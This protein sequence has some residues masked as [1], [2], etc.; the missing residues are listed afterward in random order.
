MPTHY[1]GTEQEVLALDTFIKLTR[2]SDAIGARLFQAN[3]LGSL[4][5]SQFGALEVLYHLGS[6]CQGDIGAK[7]LKSG[8]N[9]TLVIDNLEKRGLVTRRRDRDDR[10]FVTVSLTDAGRDLIMS[11]LPGHVAAIVQE[12]NV[13][14]AE[15]QRSLGQLCRKLGKKESAAHLTIEENNRG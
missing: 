1:R 15:E 6:L 4:T 11:I 12:M 14:S 2:A 7:L 13:L 3:T 9:V 5:P 10:R 8:G